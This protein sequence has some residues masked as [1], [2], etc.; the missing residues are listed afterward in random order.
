ML[1]HPHYTKRSEELK[2]EIYEYTEEL[3][4]LSKNDESLQ[5]DLKHKIKLAWRILAYLSDP[6]SVYPIKYFERHFENYRSW[7]ITLGKDL[8]ERYSIKSLVDFGCGCG[9]YLEGAKQAGAQ[10]KGYELMYETIKDMLPIEIASCIEFGDVMQPIP[11]KKFD[12]AMS[13]ETAEHIV[14]EH[15]TTLVQNLTNA[16]TRL[17]FFTAASPGQGGTG[18]VNFKSRDQWIEIFKQNGFSCLEDEVEK[19]K[20]IWLKI[21]ARKFRYLI[22]NLII[23][24]H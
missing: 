11:C 24:E 6:E 3:N 18:H 14:P 2:K 20:E 8:A 15:S 22:R 23:F 1:N 17:I 13:V 10:I 21:L 5:R 4:S 16:A 19:T 7:E 12:C 9:S